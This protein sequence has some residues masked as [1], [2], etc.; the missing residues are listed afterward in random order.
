MKALLALVGALGLLLGLNNTTVAQ[1]IC[2][3]C[4]PFGSACCAL[5]SSV[6]GCVTCSA[7]YGYDAEGAKRWCTQHQPRCARAGGAKSGCWTFANCAARCQSLYGNQ[8]A[9]AVDNCI[10]IH[11]CSKYPKSC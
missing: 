3:V 8:G 5:R 11:P 7:Q 1:D 4:K 10:S 2:A 9:A 6:K